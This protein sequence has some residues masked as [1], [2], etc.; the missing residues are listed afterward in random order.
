MLQIIFSTLLSSY[1]L[2]LSLLF[3][4]IGGTLFAQ[5]LGNSPYSVSGVGEIY[6]NAFAFGQ[7]MGEAG[8]SS[9]NGLH[10]NDLNPALW[11]RNRYTTFEF[12][13]INQYKLLQSPTARQRDFGANVAYVGIA[14]PVAP[15]WTLGFSLKPFSFVDYES[16]TRA[17]VENTIYDAYYTYSGKGA[18]NKAGF[19]NSFAL[20]KNVTIGLEA[21]YLF[22]NI[23]KSSD[24]ELLIG[25]GR[26]YLTSRVELTSYNDLMLR[27]GAA[28][29]IPV[30]KDKLNLNIGGTY[31]LQSSMNASQSVTFELTQGGFPIGVP[32]TI[33]S[34]A[35]GTAILP[36]QF[37]V[38][39]SL[40]WPY[41]LTIAAD[42]SRQSWSNYRSFN[43]LNESLGDAQRVHVGLE[44][45]PRITST[46]YFDK[47]EY[48]VGFS[49]GQLP[50]RPGGTIL[51][52]TNLSLGVTFP[53][54]RGGNS[55]SISAVV[56]ERGVVSTESIRERYGRLVFG[57][58]LVDVW[59][60]KQLID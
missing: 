17:K 16:R 12:G 50:F 3:W 40:E 28:W 46:R 11:V 49:R 9:S 27:T 18:L 47:A 45:I 41:K 5:G 2:R 43:N 59:F 6:S 48:R 19:T 8:V 23:R 13:V 51:N 38:G 54:G 60:T 34:N 7:G 35:S 55:L 32:D 53:I 24:S 22:G 57:L 1:R 36:A 39:A 14:F 58:S 31:S 4:V 30:K 37:Q 10:I 29:R 42:Y 20:H 33:R 15:K 25:D 21:A 26:D 44:Y 52:D 56:G